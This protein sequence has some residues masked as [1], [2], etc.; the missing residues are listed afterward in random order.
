MEVPREQV[1][2]GKEL[3]FT[4]LELLLEEVDLITKGFEKFLK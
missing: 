4:N 1:V 3:E 2:E